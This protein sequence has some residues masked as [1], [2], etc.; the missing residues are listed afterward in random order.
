M[1]TTAKITVIFGV[2][3]LTACNF[4]QSVAKDL[5]T[6]LETRGNGLSA[7]TVSITDG[8]ADVADNTFLYGQKIFTNFEGM[9]GFLVENGKYY[10]EMGVAVIS[11][12]GDTVLK[13]EHILGGKG[14][15]AALRTLTGNVTLATPIQT[16]NSY[17]V[18]Y[19]IT[20]TKGDGVFTSEFELDL[21]KDPVIKR[22]EKG[23]TVK[24]AYIFD[25][26][27]K[28]VRVNGTI[29]FDNNVLLDVQGLEGYRMVDG[30]P[31]LGMSLNVTDEKGRTILNM[32]DLFENR[33]LKEADI[34]RGLG[35][36]LKV[37]KGATTEDVVWTVK[38]WDKNSDA[39]VRLTAKVSIEN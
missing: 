9:D 13:N 16:G 12:Q 31:N 29:G 35:A 14:L 30:K 28:K 2:G 37:N 1:K 22:E 27:S 32:N 34:K 4:N 10:P 26:D 5:M 11:K 6:G 18:L 24:E 36:T 19:T 21:K 3:L 17:T 38:I 7:N 39:T 8:D 20:D 25:Q 15:D 33:P 23:L